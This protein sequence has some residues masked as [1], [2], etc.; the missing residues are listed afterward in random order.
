VQTVGPLYRHGLVRLP[1][2]ISSGSKAKVMPLVREVTRWPDA[3][4]EDCLMAQWFLEFKLPVLSHTPKPL[5]DQARPAIVRQLA[6]RRLT[7]TGR[8]A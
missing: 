7:Y 2:E 8:S 5:P 1:G 4:T 6:H 3:S